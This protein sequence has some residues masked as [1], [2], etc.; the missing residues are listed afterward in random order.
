[1]PTGQGTDEAVAM[2]GRRLFLARSVLC[3]GGLACLGCGRAFA[4]QQQPAGGPAPAHKFDADAKMTFKEMYSFAYGGYISLLK[5]LAD[6]IGREKFL[7]ML[8]NAASRAV[9]DRIRKTA[10]PPPKNTLAAYIVQE[11]E[12]FWSH[13]VTMNWVEKT[14]TTAETR[15]TEC[16]WATTFRAADAA[17]IG[18][19][20]VCHADFAATTAFNPK[21]RM[22]RTKTLMQGHDCC[23]HRWVMQA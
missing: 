8:Q 17:D 16:L 9:A 4:G 7:S 22:L 15:V 1:M 23:N 21:M 6:D 19:A 10:P 12:Y 20:T 3:A 14:D 13:V 11:P 2:T 18:Y 5:S